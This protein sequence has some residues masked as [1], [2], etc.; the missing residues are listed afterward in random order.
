MAMR[1]ESWVVTD[2]FWQRVE[3]LVPQRVPSPDK[4]YLRKPGAGRPPKPARQVFEAIVYV[5][6]TG[7]QWKALPKE[8]FGSASA[9]HKR[10]LEWEE[11]GFFEA[12]WKAGLAEYDEME[13]IAWRWQSVDGAMMKAPLAQEAV[14]PNPTD[15]GKKGGSKRHLLVDGRGVPLSLIVT[16]A[17]VNDGK[18]LN[19][20]LNAIVVKRR[21]PPVRRSK[22]LCADAGYRSAENLRTIETHRYIPHVVSHRQEADIKGRDPSK[23]AKRWVVEVAHSWFNRFRKLLVRYEKLERSF[24]ALNHLAAAIIAFRNVPLGINIIY[25]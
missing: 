8:R 7:C 18:R 11:A 2:A 14:G 1:V 15:R 25:G 4:Q 24:L 20:V 16:G 3:P 5:L 22:H 12:V 13:G 10:F 9:I 6:R 19:E 23:K 21:C 17:N